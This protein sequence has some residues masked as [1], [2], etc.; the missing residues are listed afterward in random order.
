MEESV[1]AARLIPAYDAEAQR[2]EDIYPLHNVIPELEWAALDSLL[3]KLKNATD[4]RARARLLPNARSDWIRQHL[5]L[6]YSSKPK[7]KIVF[8]PLRTIYRLVSI[9]PN[10]KQKDVDIL[11]DDVRIPRC[12]GEKCPRENR[13]IGAS[14]ARSGSCGRRPSCT[15]YGNTQ[16]ILCVSLFISTRYSAHMVCTGPG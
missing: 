11:L 7:S 9:I 5:M 8:V 16:R 1:N 10:F 6:A 14:G 3:P 12:G 2:P 15:I 13:N 4:D